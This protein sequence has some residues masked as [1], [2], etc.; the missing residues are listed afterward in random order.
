DVR[1]EVRAHAEPVHVMALVGNDEAV[2]REGPLSEIVHEHGVW[3]YLLQLRCVPRDLREVH[4]AVVLGSVEATR[5][6]GPARSGKPRARQALEVAL[7][8]E[9]GRLQSTDERR[10]VELV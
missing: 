8:R 10:V 3:D 2:I 7:P 6:V 9:A 1:L 4:E 5:R